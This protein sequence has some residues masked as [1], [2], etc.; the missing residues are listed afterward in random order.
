MNTHSVDVV[1]CA[2][3]VSLTAG[4]ETRVVGAQWEKSPARSDR[5]YGRLGGFINVS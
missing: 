4:G 5:G 3:I 1:Y 2:V